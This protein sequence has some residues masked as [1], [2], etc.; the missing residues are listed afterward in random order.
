M[1]VPLL[2]SVRKRYAYR[3][4]AE[5]RPQTGRKQTALSL[6][7]LSLPRDG[8]LS[9]FILSKPSDRAVARPRIPTRWR[10]ALALVV[11]YKGIMVLWYRCVTL[12]Q[13]H[14]PVAPD[15]LLYVPS[16]VLMGIQGLEH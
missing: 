10:G 13:R 14:G 11:R 16:S 8:W 1:S 4:A 12:G 6:P 3:K 7:N 2:L 15:C 9:F 5:K